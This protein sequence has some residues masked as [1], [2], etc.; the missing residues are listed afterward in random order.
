MDEDVRWSVDQ[1]EVAPGAMAPARFVARFGHRYNLGGIFVR[2]AERHPDSEARAWAAEV[3]HVLSGA[4]GSLDQ[5]RRTE[6]SLRERVAVW[7][8]ARR[9]GDDIA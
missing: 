8:E 6:L 5:L 3:M 4:R 1:L 9:I 7:R 2:I